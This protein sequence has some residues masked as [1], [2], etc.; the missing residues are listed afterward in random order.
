VQQDGMYRGM[1]TNTFTQCKDSAEVSIKFTNPP[2]NLSLNANAQECINAPV[3]LVGNALGDDLV[4]TWTTANG[5]G[6]ISNFNLPNAQYNPNERLDPVAPNFITIQ[7]KVSNDC[8]ADSV[9]KNIILNPAVIPAFKTDAKETLP[10]ETMNF[11]NITDTLNKGKV[12]FQWNFGDGVKSTTFNASHIYGDYGNFLVMLTAK[13]SFNCVDTATLKVE[14]ISSSIFY[15]PNVF[16]PST[17]N[18]ENKAVKIYGVALA[19]EGFSWNIYNRW[20]EVIYSATNP[21]EATNN[22]WNGNFKNTGEPLPIGVYTY[23]LK[24][25]FADGRKI[26]KTGT[27]SLIR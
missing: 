5:K 4:Y 17:T 14:V 13:N 16:A 1:V 9:S 20:G 11:Y 3:S 7:L 15:I 22:G 12:S 26:E 23:T 24:A 18:A 25:K 19:P 10:G 8:K 27:I 6:I 21:E 2:S